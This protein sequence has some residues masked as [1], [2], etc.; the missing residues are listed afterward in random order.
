[1]KASERSEV[2]KA[3]K[4]ANQ[5]NAADSRLA[6]LAKKISVAHNPKSTACMTLR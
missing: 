5:L 2:G 3:T 1:M 6:V 4:H